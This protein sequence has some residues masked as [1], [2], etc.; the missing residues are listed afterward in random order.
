MTLIQSRMNADKNENVTFKLLI[1]F[2]RKRM[3]QFNEINKQTAKEQPSKYFY[4]K[5]KAS[6][7]FGAN[8]L[9]QNATELCVWFGRFNCYFPAWA[10]ESKITI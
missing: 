4:R 5:Q 9:E 7:Y 8:I 6:I 10:V 3:Y 2:F 1:D